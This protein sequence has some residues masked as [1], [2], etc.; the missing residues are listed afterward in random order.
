[1]LQRAS[2]GLGSRVTRR[3]V[4][5]RLRLACHAIALLATF[6]SPVLADDR[7]VF[8][9]ETFQRTTG[10]P[11]TVTR[12]FQIATTNASYRLK[13]SNR[14]VTSATVSVNGVAILQPG[15]FMGT[16]TA[17]ASFERDIVVHAGANRMDVQV[18]GA[19][20]TSFIIEILGT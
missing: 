13:L 10:Q 8:G 6:V 20:G 19:P 14:G 16:N 9:P 12:T 1:M 3:R 7:I 4:F 18:R 17:S 15:D 2:N 11:R 5:V